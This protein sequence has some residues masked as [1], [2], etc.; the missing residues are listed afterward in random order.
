MSNE[1]E[2]KSKT[3]TTLKVLAFAAL[4][5]VFCKAVVAYVSGREV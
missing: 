5:G 2:K 3:K 4:L 1:I